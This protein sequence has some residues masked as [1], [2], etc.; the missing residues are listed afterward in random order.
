M[1]N[2][3]TTVRISIL[4]KDYTFGGW[5]NC[6]GAWK[7]TQVKK[8]QAQKSNQVSFVVIDFWMTVTCQNLLLVFV[9][10]VVLMITIQQLNS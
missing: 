6:C 9:T 7:S 10:S 2:L 4:Y 5:C 1:T 3:E 8:N